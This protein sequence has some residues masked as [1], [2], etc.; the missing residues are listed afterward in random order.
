MAVGTERLDALGL[1]TQK[2]RATKITCISRTFFQKIQIMSVVN[3]FRWKKLFSMKAIWTFK[4]N[5]RVS[6]VD[7][8]NVLIVKITASDKVK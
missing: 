3:N 6:R 2:R 1:M 4:A 8:G 5:N 7:F